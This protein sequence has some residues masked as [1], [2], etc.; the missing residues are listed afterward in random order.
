MGGGHDGENDELRPMSDQWA[1]RRASFWEVSNEWGNAY[2]HT[3]QRGLTRCAGW[4]CQHDMRDG[5]SRCGDTRK[6]K[7]DDGHGGVWGGCKWAFTARERER[8]RE[9][10]L[11]TEREC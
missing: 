1:G 4:G 9:R 5:L 6:E 10:V 11:K 2:V 7:S 8:E 3:S